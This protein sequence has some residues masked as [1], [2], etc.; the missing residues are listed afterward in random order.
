[1]ADNNEG[2]QKEMEND[3]SLLSQNPEQQYTYIE[4]ACSKLILLDDEAINKNVEKFIDDMENLER[5]FQKQYKKYI[6]TK[7]EMCKE[8]YE[9]IKKL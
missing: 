3:L 4:K 7:G 8:M 2:L 9:E 6:D 5:N 1:M